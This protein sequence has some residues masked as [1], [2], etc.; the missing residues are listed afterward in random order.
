MKKKNGVWGGGG[1][2]F[3]FLSIHKIYENRMDHEL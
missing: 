2:G 3:L 1:D